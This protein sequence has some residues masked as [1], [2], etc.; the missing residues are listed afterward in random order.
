MN[1]R[2]QFHTSDIDWNL[3]PE[4]L[5]EV[6]MAYHSAECHQLAF[7]KSHSVV[8]VWDENELIGFGR[9]ISDGILQAA[10]Y[11]VAVHPSYQGKGIGKT[12]VS[13]LVQHCP[14]CNVILYA[15]PG[16][17]QFYEKLNFR[18]MK[19]AMALFKDAERKR[20]RGFTE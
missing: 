19:T 8:F 12:I 13:E 16:K 15:S 5:K 7:E 6:G 17:E 3:V 11:D 9:A 18:R 1:L 20:E 2:L 10:L 4:I 14:G